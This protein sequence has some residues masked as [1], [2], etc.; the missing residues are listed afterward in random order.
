MGY[1]T[2]DSHVPT[3]ID[4]EEQR[5]QRDALAK[6]QQDTAEYDHHMTS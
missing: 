4:P 1:G 2:S 6:L 3:Y 5:R